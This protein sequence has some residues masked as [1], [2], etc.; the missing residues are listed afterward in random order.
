MI[1]TINAKPNLVLKSSKD[2]RGAAWLPWKAYKPPPFHSPIISK[3]T[4]TASN[5]D[6]ALV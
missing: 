3:G 5:L 1:V 2:P 4:R 6:F